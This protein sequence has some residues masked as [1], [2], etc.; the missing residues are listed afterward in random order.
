MRAEKADVTAGRSLR[1]WAV[2][3]L[4]GIAIVAATL[5]VQSAPALAAPTSPSPAAPAPAS[6]P[7]GN[8]NPVTWSVQPATAKKP[9]TRPTYSYTNYRPGSTH[10]DYV[11]ID[12]F[13]TTP[14]TFAVYASDAFNTAGGGFDL[15]AAAEKP[16]DVGSWVRFAKSS[17]RVPARSSVIVPFTVTIPDNATPGFHVGGVVASLSVP[18]VDSKGNQV[19]A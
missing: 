11:A 18:G 5:A 4:A 6:G 7:T 8:S 2:I 15:L 13:S 16:K 19:H 12:N 3:G 1:R 9:D 17:V 10:E 14:Q